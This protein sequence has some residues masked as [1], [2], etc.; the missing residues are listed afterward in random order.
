MYRKA[1]FNE[2]LSITQTGRLRMN[3]RPCPYQGPLC[4]M[5][6]SCLEFI[7]HVPLKRTHLLPRWAFRV[8]ARPRG[9]SIAEI[10]KDGMNRSLR[11]CLCEMSEAGCVL[12]LTE[13]WFSYPR[14]SPL[15]LA[16]RAELCLGGGP[17]I[18]D[19]KD[20]DPAFDPTLLPSP[21]LT[22]NFSLFLY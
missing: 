20:A 15:E 14:C 9:Y 12:S 5:V 4:V 11:F 10:G 17:I 22:G 7:T 2:S 13:R 1:V 3:L 6:V 21:T 19:N 18:R 16:L 8:S